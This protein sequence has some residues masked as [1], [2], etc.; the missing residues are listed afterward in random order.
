[1]I[2]FVQI[3]N[4]CRQVMFAVI[5][6]LQR[7]DHITSK[8]GVRRERIKRNTSNF[9]EIFSA[10]VKNFFAFAE[11]FLTLPETRPSL[12]PQNPIRHSAC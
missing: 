9:A 4:E 2:A 5:L 8:S 6:N 10:L 3:M 11:Y 1:M 7:L 12:K